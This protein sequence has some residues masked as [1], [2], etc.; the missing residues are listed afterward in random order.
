METSPPSPS[1]ISDNDPAG[2]A[3]SAG[4]SLAE[5]GLTTLIE[6]DARRQLCSG[7]L[8][9]R[10]RLAADEV[11]SLKEPSPIFCCA[12]R[13]SYLPF[14]FND[15]YEHF[16][17]FLPPKLGQ[18]NYEVWVDYNNVPLKWQYPLGVL[19]DV[20]VG[21]DVPTPLDLAVHFRSC[22]TKEVMPYYC[23]ADL[24]RVFMNS[25]RQAVYLNHRSAAPF[26]RLQKAPQTQLWESI[27]RSSLESDYSDVQRQL[28]CKNLAS[29]SSLALR[30]HLQA[31]GT[32]EV[33]LHPA[34]ALQKDGSPQTLFGFLLEVL[35]PLFPDVGAAAGAGAVGTDMAKLLY[36]GV[37][38]LT[39]GL[40][41]PLETPLYWLALHAA[42]LDQ[43][44]HIVVR[45]PP[46][47][48]TGIQSA[49]NMGIGLA[50]DVGAQ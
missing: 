4:A 35:P 18:P 12:A 13:I 48:A 29:C 8:L 31:A 26:M 34:P 23:I 2:V 41:I 44:V 20:L 24:Q 46:Q 19:C 40:A 22:P 27:A 16:Q 45:I 9:L 3:S 43:F 30:I 39:Q 38:V 25:F 49:S 11:A 37:E 32:H 6:E 5:V 36:E 47:L 14:L 15:V 50:T 10:I 42:Y 7:R 28:L 21:K 33:V 1:A 17:T